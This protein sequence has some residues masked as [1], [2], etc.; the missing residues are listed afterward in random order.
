MLY[1]LVSIALQIKDLFS[2]KKRRKMPKS[3][4]YIQKFL[5]MAEYNELKSAY[6]Q[7][8]VQLI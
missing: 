4:L 8:F 5:C 2:P 7:V 3:T 1:M 6:I